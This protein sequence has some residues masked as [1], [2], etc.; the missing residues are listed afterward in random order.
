MCKSAEM[1]PD[2]DEDNEDDGW[3]CDEE[4]VADGA[5]AAQLAAHFDSMLQVS[6]ELEH[7]VTESGQFDDAIE[8]SLL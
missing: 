4:E 1:N 3:I 7:C 5:R 2:E 8:E 6:P